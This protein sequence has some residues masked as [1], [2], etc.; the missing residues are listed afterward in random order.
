MFHAALVT[1]FSLYHGGQQFAPTESAR[2]GGLC[3]MH[4]TNCWLF[5]QFRLTGIC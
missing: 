4:D 5:L 2:V 3:A 1:R